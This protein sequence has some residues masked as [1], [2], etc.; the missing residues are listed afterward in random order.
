MDLMINNLKQILFQLNGKKPWSR[1]Y[2]A[3]RT[4]FLTRNLNNDDFKDQNLKKNYGQ[5]FDE[6]VIEY[7]WLFSRLSKDKTRLLDAGSVLNFDYILN[8]PLL[9]DKTITISTLAPEQNCFWFKNISYV[10]EDFRQSCFKDNY[11]DEIVC[12]STLEHVGLDNNRYFEETKSSLQSNAVKKSL[13]EPQGNFL[14]AITELKRILKPG[15]KLYLSMPFGKQKSHGWFQVF[16]AVMVDQI[17]T[18]F[19][20][21]SP[22]EWIF[23]YTADGWKLSSRDES[24]NSIYLDK[25]NANSKT[26]PAA[27]EAVI[28]IELQKIHE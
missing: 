12:L 13:S 21:T 24:K 9:K 14:Q 10:F 27:A 23:L 15:G 18:T 2:I 5:G 3:S 25:H 20:A 22:K 7:P 19:S 17:Y 6:R 28:C 26:T 1:G 16:D 8:H 4:D 11:F